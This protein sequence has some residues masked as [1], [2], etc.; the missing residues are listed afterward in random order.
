MK[1]IIKNKEIELKIANN[2][3]KRLKGFMF[4]KDISYCLRFKTNSIHT[5][6]MKQNIDLVMTDKNNKVLFIIRNLP[7]NKIVIHKNVYYSYEFP[8]DFIDNL[9]IGDILI[10]K[11]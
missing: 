6:F 5:F 8:R 9:I 11:D 3:F 1:V 2:F 4:Q 10:I 7:K